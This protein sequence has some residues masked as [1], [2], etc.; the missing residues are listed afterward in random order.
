MSPSTLNIPSDMFFLFI[1][2]MDEAMIDTILDPQE[3]YMGLDCNDFSNYIT[4]HIQQHR[5]LGDTSLLAL[6]GTF[7]NGTQK[8]M[9]FVGNHSKQRFNIIVE[10]NA[11]KEITN[12]TENADF[13]FDEFIFGNSPF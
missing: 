4:Q 1:I 5:N 9:S 10:V 6:N 11:Q 2:R 7:D 3:K 12:I 13:Q 8:G